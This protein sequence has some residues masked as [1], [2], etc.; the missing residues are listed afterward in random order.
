MLY[1][2]AKIPMMPIMINKGFK[3]PTAEI[4]SPVPHK[5]VIW[6]NSRIR[7]DVELGECCQIGSNVYIDAGVIIGNG[8][9]IQNGAQLFTGV[10]LEDDVFIGPNVTFTNVKEPR[11]FINKHDEFQKTLVKKGAS[12]GAGAVI[13]CGITIGKFALVGAGAVISRDVE[14]YTCILSRQSRREVYVCECGSKLGEVEG[15]IYYC[16]K[17][18]AQYVWNDGLEK[19]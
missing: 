17:C 12:I 14:D 1:K 15:N 3:H 7:E 19:I 13:V 5:T 16:F 2:G 6:A 9:K 4:L 10:I 11:A 8:C 18:E